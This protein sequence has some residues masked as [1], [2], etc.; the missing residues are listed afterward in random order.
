MKPSTPPL[1]VADLRELPMPGPAERIAYGVAD[2]QFGELRVPDSGNK[3][4]PVLMLL[5]GGCWRNHVGL[6]YITPLAQWFAERGVATW[7]PEYRR[8]GDDGG[9]WPGTLFDAGSALDMVRTIARTKPLD[10]QR[11]FVAGHS[12]GGQL[13][14][15][16][17]SRHRLGPTSDL[18][19]PDPL[20]VRG[21]I[22]L[23]AITNLAEYRHGPP[24]SCHA[25]V[26]QLMG[27]SPELFAQRYLDASPS[28]RLPLQVPQLF[29]HGLQDDIVPIESVHA[30]I[31][32]A[33]SV[34]E[35]IRLMQLPE[36]GH[37]EPAVFTAA[38][39]GALTAALD[40]ILDAETVLA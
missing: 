1:T 12:A 5:H 29:I 4:F 3:P 18:F 40:W 11:V 20:P 33:S 28:E 6:G 22:G 8:L 15:W 25:S 17:S 35:T 37:F 39:E 9:G 31:K 36:G 21:V 38:S 30:Y 32:A 13:A 16:A 14:L 19:Q 7:V 27:G 2:Q 23:A 34:G 24:D 10:L 26:E